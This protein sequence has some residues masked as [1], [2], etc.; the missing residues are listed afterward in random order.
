MQAPFLLAFILLAFLLPAIEQPQSYHAFADART[1]L[2][3]PNFWDTVSNL[4]LVLVGL[5][6][7]RELLSGEV[8][9]F[10]EPRER[11]PYA[12]FFLCVLL[13]GI[14]S[15]YYHLDPNDARLL[16]DR[17]PLVLTSGALVV[18]VLGD[19]T[20]PPRALRDLLPTLLICATTVG[21]WALGTGDG[22]G[23]L[24]PYLL[25]QVYVVAATVFIL[26]FRSPRYTRRADFAVVIVC[27]V[28]S[29]AA[30]WLDA[31]IY[32]LGHWLSGHT[33]KHLIAALA[34]G[35]LLRM[36]RRRTSSPVYLAPA[37]PAGTPT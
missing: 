34:C 16:W 21:Y 30:E 27:Y 1:L 31:Q 33:L 10:R 25:L 8:H 11:W 19:H 18:A 5:A 22:T 29:R 26:L 12:V 13:T 4:G 9:G 36:I 7:L 32:S 17:L 14:G 28:L 3:V 15:A 37:V 35:W 2:G 24:T 20:Q 6:G 23:N